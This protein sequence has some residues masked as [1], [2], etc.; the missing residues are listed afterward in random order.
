[1][2]RFRLNRL[3]AVIALAAFALWPATIA[4]QGAEAAAAA[5]PWQITDATGSD[6]LYVPREIARAYDRGTRSRDGTP[7]PKYWQNQSKHTIK[8][9]ISPPDKRITGEQEIV[10][11]NNSPDALPILVFRIYLNSHQ[12]EAMRDRPYPSAFLGKGVSVESFTINGTP[13]VWDDSRFA[14]Y[15]PPGSTTHVLPLEQPLAPGA[16]ITMT[17]RWSY[18]LAPDSGW[19]EGAID[20]TS[21]FLA[22]FFPRVSNYSDYG[23]W[24]FA[25]FTTGRE[26]NNDFADFDVT[27][28]APRDFVVWATGE[29][30]NPDAVLQPDIAKRLKASRTSDKV[31]T[32]A[33]PEDVSA[34][35]VTARAER[36]QWRWQARHVP[37]FAL[38]I[39]N[40]YRWQASSVVVDPATGRRTAVEAA[41][42]PKATDF[43]NSV[44]EARE[45]L[46]FG[47]TEWPGVPYPYPK[48]TIV[49]GSADEEYP[50]MV[51]DAS[52]VGSTP[53]AG[54]SVNDYTAF[55]GAHEILHSWFPFFMGINEKRYPF[56]DEGWTTSFEYLRNRKVLGVEAAD[57][58]YKRFRVTGV[59]WV[60]PTS[61]N[62]LPIITP[63]D[64]LYGMTPVFA[65]NQYGKAS[66]GYLALKDLMGDAAF[67]RA[68]HTFMTRWNGKR[69][70]PWDMF[71]S[72]NAAGAGD[73]D[74]FFN[75][76]FFGYNYMDLAIA[77][78]TSG[79]DGHA[80]TLRNPGGMAVPFDAV[81][82]Y[83]DGSSER[84][85]RTPAAWKDNPR[86]TVVRAASG[87]ALQSV[88]IDT[89]L[90]VDFVPAD[91]EWKVGQ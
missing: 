83:A 27:V 71:A 43:T 35:R 72:F 63:H 52:N 78:V 79:A 26:F 5:P 9:A 80:V 3:R 34:G 18:E 81:L 46:A 12:P 13:A 15:N 89:G 69:P 90:F 24:D 23:N 85:H 11:T 54:V 30:A 55:V 41:Y 17:M 20:E 44:E 6:E 68:L 58:L 49:L 31:V 48:T 76:W 56:M 59:G 28:D 4:A 33:E 36:L 66:L 87:K 75:N 19:K 25:P 29:L 53:P 8:L 67:K 82:T 70:L 88:V 1:M 40:H 60:D 64:S 74:W 21:Y 37:D 77:G 45:T 84:L 39:S 7:G 38:A 50:M 51:N 86:E 22:Y 62:E 2:K 32:L 42:V 73:H 65:F 16:S 10:Y 47:S 57:A 61:G 14:A 91:N